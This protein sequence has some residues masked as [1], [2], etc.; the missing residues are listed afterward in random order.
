MSSTK[1]RREPQDAPGTP[2]PGEPV[3]LPDELARLIEER[4]GVEPDEGGDIVV[5][6]PVEPPPVDPAN[7]A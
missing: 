1:A 3:D 4:D 5:D 2:P 7:F 6:P